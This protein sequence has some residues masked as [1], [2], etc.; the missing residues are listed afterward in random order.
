MG[1]FMRLFVSAPSAPSA[2][3]SILAGGI[4]SNRRH[5][6][7]RPICEFPETPFVFADQL[8][9]HA[10]VLHRRWHD[11]PGVRLHLKMRAEVWVRFECVHHAE[12]MVACVVEERGGTAVERDVKMNAP[13]LGLGIAD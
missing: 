1:L 6:L 9:H 10:A 13:F 11:L 8:V 2:V 12:E 7:D 5:G 3:P 4:L